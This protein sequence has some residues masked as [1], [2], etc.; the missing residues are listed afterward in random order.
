MSPLA[1][2]LREIRHELGLS[3]LKFAEALGLKGPQVC[4]ME[5]GKRYAPALTK[6]KPA[7]DRLKLTPRQQDMI[8][9]ASHRSP[10]M[11]RIPANAHQNAFSC[12]ATIQADFDYFHAEDFLEIEEHA[13]RISEKRK[14]TA[15][16]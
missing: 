7:M 11:V 15:V 10:K 4:Y 16:A 14:Q 2:L 6:L 5:A 9:G 8:I 1:Q 3:Q 12:F 13:K